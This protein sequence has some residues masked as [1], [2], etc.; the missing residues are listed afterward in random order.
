MLFSTSPPSFTSPTKLMKLMKRHKSFETQT[1][2]DLW[3][4]WKAGR[5]LPRVEAVVSSAECPLLPKSELPSLFLSFTPLFCEWPSLRIAA[6]LFG[7]SSINSK[8]HR[9][10]TR[11]MPTLSFYG[12]P[13]VPTGDWF[14]DTVGAKSRGCQVSHVK[15]VKWRSVCMSPVFAYGLSRECPR[16]PL[17]SGFSAVLG[18]WQI[19]VFLFETFWNFFKKYFW[20]LVGWTS[21]DMKTQIWKSNGFGRKYLLHWGAQPQSHITIAWDTY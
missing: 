18:M 10:C 2:G 21:T 11:I 7:Q 17:F 20:S 3:A 9:D 6:C 15:H 19:Q 12:H 16:I 13:Y 14:Q 1:N 5:E 8:K 4:Q